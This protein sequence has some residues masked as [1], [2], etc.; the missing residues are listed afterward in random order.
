MKI[1]TK[2]ADSLQKKLPF[3]VYR[4]PNS[5]VLNSFFQ[6]NDLLF[7]LDD[8]SESGFAFAPFDEDKKPIFF[9][10]NQGHF[11][12]EILDLDALEILQK[13]DFNT[14]TQKENHLQIVQKAI[15]KIQQGI[16]KKVVIS[17]KEAVHLTHFQLVEVF[18]KLLHNYQNA[19]VYAW[20]HPKV[21]LWLG[22]TPETL[23]TIDNLHFETMSLAGTQVAEN[24]EA[25]VWKQ[26]ELEEQSLVTDFIENQLKNKV[27]NLKISSVE[28]VKAG[29]LF[30]LKTAI[31]GILDVSKSSLKELVECLHPTPAVCGFPRNEARKFIQE[32]ELYDREFYTGFLGELNFTSEN[33]ETKKTQ[34]FVNLRCMKI[35]G[36]TANLFIG[37]GI[38]KDSNP[39]KEWQETVSKSNTMKL[40]L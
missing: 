36:N 25:V 18:Q 15:D 33:T 14:H 12:T 31:S 35:E 2:I 7:F 26:K 23:L 39:E 29:K 20:F 11:F 13:N 34:L 5:T 28:T 17:R 27:S 40:V 22:A 10:K 3:V 30:H 21:G 1:V 6:K 8:F 16:L 9:P 19:F 24:L 38:T 32:N 37:G 4:K